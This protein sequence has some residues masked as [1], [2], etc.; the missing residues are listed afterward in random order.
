MQPTENTEV[1]QPKGGLFVNDFGDE[2]C[3]DVCDRKQHLGGKLSPCYIT[4]VSARSPPSAH[5]SVSVLI[6]RSWPIGVAP[7]ESREP[8]VNSIASSPRHT[9]VTRFTVLP[10]SSDEARRVC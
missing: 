10:M 6:S 8:S 5:V 4:G 2:S 1:S 9:R 3:R 7:T